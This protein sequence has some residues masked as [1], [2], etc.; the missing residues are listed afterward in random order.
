MQV[1][2][3]TPARRRE[4]RFDVVVDGSVT[5][6]LSIEA[7]ER[8][9]LSVGT[10]VDDLLSAALARETGIVATY[11]RALNLLALRARSAS[12][13]RRALIRK[14]EP[15]DQ[16]DAAIERLLRAG[17][18]DDAS[19]AKQFVRSRAVGGGLSRRRVQQELRRRGV[20]PELADAAIQE[21]FADERVDDSQAL[22]RAARKKLKTLGRVDEPTRKRRLY[23]Y[24]ARRGY[25]SHDIGRVINSLISASDSD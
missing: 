12:E 9:H 15:P 16:V 5:A 13:M 17:F 10:I 1:T 8:L 4:G 14:G 7:I 18:L 3:I 2:A 6:T 25:D 11:D 19:F 21:V 23:A 20:S 22:E 24:L